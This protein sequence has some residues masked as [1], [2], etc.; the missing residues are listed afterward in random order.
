[1]EV[2]TLD[3]LEYALSLSPYV[4]GIT[5]R[6][7]WT[8]DL[9]D[10]QINLL[11]PHLPPNVRVMVMDGLHTMEEVERIIDVGVDAILL[12]ES[13]LDHPDQMAELH[14]RLQRPHSTHP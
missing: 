12:H 14:Q 2:H 6:D 5:D 13:L 4:I 7:P 9:L 1:V 10:E 11:R 3:E 8:N